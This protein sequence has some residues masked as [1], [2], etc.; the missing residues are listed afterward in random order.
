MC[1]GEH[2]RICVQACAPAG[3]HACVSARR[4]AG[5][6]AGQRTNSEEKGSV[7]DAFSEQVQ[8]L[9]HVGRRGCM[10]ISRQIVTARRQSDRVSGLHGIQ[11]LSR[12]TVDPPCRPTEGSPS[13]L[14]LVPFRI[15]QPAMQDVLAARHV[16]TE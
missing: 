14:H 5:R 13:M 7:Q 1:G 3:L 8:T 4:R 11:P 9:Y 6:Q 12:P 15:Q 16:L 10:R 2:G